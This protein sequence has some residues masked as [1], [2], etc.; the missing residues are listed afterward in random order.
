MSEIQWKEMVR[1]FW[2]K[3]GWYPDY[4]DY[5]DVQWMVCPVQFVTGP[6]PPMISFSYNTYQHITQFDWLQIVFY[7]NC[8]N[9]PV[10]FFSENLGLEVSRCRFC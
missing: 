5:P 7:F 2:L 6:P 8:I 4:P 3:P 9:L 1:S 10:I